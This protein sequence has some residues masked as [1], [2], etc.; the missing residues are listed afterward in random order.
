MR[1][2]VQAERQCPGCGHDAGVAVWHEGG[3]RYLRCE[4]CG[5]VFADLPLDR[6]RSAQHNAW[7]EDELLPEV[8][9]FYGDAR[10]DAHIEFLR[11]HQPFGEHRL[12]DVGC[13]LG[14]FASRALEAGW[15]VV[16]CEPASSWAARASDR[17][18]ADRVIVGTADDRALD[19][20]RFD[21]ITA[22]DV[23]EHV[24]DPLPFL[25]RLRELLAPEGRIFL[26]TPNLTYVLPV[27]GLRR[28][29]LGHEVEL[30]PT[31]HVV[32][33]TAATLRAALAQARFTA[34]DWRNLP[35]PQV[36]V[37]KAPTERASGGRR[38]SVTA[39]NA[40]ARFATKIARLTAGR[41]VVSSDLDVEAIGC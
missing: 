21:L 19:D 2:A 23:I 26:R 9:A 20:Q 3:Y 15:D 39:K 37:R 27:Y 10:E 36:A 18:G 28:F 32:Y 38:W 13:G 1:R 35:P 33:F 30:G 5:V 17:V 6:Y 25:S 31:N 40:Y 24:F 12:L 29:V 14:F 22:W 8:S 41:L 34:V 4:R 11:R 16:G 7:N